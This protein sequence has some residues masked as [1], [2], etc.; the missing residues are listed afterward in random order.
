MKKVLLLA[1]VSSFA[2][3]GCA[4]QNVSQSS[5]PLV[6]SVEAPL[7]A[8]VDV[9]EKITGTAQ[10]TQIFGFIKLGPNKFADGVTYAGAS[11]GGLL[12]MLD[13]SESVKAAAAYN[14]TSK[15]NADVIVAPRYTIETND[16][17][18]FKTTKATVNGYK[19]TI[20]SITKK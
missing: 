9:G 3:V 10:S 11:G 12:S 13:S 7:K 20:N 1:A 15:S 18:V 6:S 19:G 14:A 16:Y 2:M 4:S 17:F 5:S 8:D